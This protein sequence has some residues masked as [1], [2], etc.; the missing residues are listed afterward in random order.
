MHYVVFPISLFLSRIVRQVSIHAFNEN[1]R[2]YDILAS[3]RKSAA[4]MVNRIFLGYR[5]R[6][7]YKVRELNSQ[8]RIK[9][10]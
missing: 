2:N 9:A 8:P 7:E 1:G 5:E 10:Y 6:R 4:T 3:E